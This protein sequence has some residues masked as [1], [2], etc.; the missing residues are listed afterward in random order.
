MHAHVPPPQALLNNQQRHNYNVQNL[1]SL[2]LKCEYSA[3]D[4][5][6]AGGESCFR[7]W[8]KPCDRVGWVPIA[9]KLCKIKMSDP[10]LWLIGEHMSYPYVGCF[11]S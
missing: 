6:L 11:G 4:D 10:L 5:E 9:V 2:L 1:R 7:R 8:L 3:I